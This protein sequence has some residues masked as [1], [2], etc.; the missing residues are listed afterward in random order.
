MWHVY[1]L[2]SRD[3]RL[4]TGITTDIPRRIAKHQSGKGA[5]FTRAFGCVELLYKEDHENRSAALKRE[6]EIKSW[7]RSQ[8]LQLIQEQSGT[9]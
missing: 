1:I 3:G 5:K 8:K 4:Y 9:K 7:P 6:A 2:Q